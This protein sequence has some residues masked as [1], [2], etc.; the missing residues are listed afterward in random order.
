MPSG[1]KNRN[2]SVNQDSKNEKISGE[3]LPP[4]PT[5]SPQV[6]TM[7]WWCICRVVMM[8]CELE[9]EGI[10]MKGLSPAWT[11]G[12]ARGS[13]SGGGG[14]M[15]YIGSIT[16]GIRVNIPLVR[17]MVTLKWMWIFFLGV[18]WITRF[19]PVDIELTVLLL[20]KVYWWGKNEHNRSQIMWQNYCRLLLLKG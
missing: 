8:Q 12:Q 14:M 2:C 19:V 16:Y 17:P 10:P 3:H 4:V 1:C 15:R 20:F 13:K 9:R 18:P 11:K 6:A 5:P 7:K